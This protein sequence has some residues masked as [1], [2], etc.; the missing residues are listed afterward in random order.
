[1]KKLSAL[2]MIVN[3]CHV[4]AMAQRIRHHAY[5]TYYNASKHEPDS[6]SWDVTSVMLSNDAIATPGPFKV[7]PKINSCAKPND[8]IS[9]GYTVGLLFSWKNAACNLTDQVECLYMSNALPV[10]SRCYN[11]DWQA[12]DDYERSLAVKDKIHV[13][14]GGWGSMLESTRSGLTIPKRI[15]KA[16]YADG[17]WTVWIVD[18]TANAV[19]HDYR[20]WLSTVEQLNA[21]TGLNLQNS[22]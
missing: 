9:P 15:W 7:D 12:I 1:M 6:V 17:R 18:N 5:T 16:V 10:N 22:H 14:A 4:S 20:Y 3:V 19:G 8:Y 11:S 13:I 2:I 21:I